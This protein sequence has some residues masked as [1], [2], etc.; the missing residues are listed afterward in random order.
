MVVL[1]CIF[2]YDI[3]IQLYDLGQPMSTKK[4]KTGKESQ[5]I[6]SRP[7]PG[8]DPPFG[9]D[10][11]SMTGPDSDTLPGFSGWSR[12]VKSHCTIPR[13]DTVELH[14]KEGSKHVH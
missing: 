7:E 8:S 3:C 9:S 11:E 1:F 6:V 2:V 5:Y 4:K 14:F 13:E 12:L 10:R